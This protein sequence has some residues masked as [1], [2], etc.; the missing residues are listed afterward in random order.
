MTDDHDFPGIG[1]RRDFDRLG[2]SPPAD[3]CAVA[4]EDVER[5]SAAGRPG[6]VKSH[7]LDVV[8]VDDLGVA[9]NAVG[10]VVVVAVDKNEDFAVL[11]RPLRQR[12][13]QLPDELL[14]LGDRLI[15]PRGKMPARIGDA[16][17]LFDVPRTT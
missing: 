3:K 7:G 16:A 2:K 12:H 17:C 6:V 1:L 10:E 9:E 13:V 8:V 11:G 5:D 14:S 4:V 15:R